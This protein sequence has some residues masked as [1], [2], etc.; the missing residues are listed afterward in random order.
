MANPIRNCMGCGTQ[1]DHPRHV[2]GDGG[3]AG[4]DI[5]WHHDCHFRASGCEVCEAVSAEGLTGDELRAH[6]EDNDPGGAVAREINERQAPWTQN[7]NL[8]TQEA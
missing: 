5:F 2:L 1:D 6:I 3:G 4:V 8:E 7:A